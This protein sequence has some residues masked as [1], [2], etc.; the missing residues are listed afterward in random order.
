MKW[1]RKPADSLIDYTA[2]RF[3]ERLKSRVLKDI[4]PFIAELGIDDVVDAGHRTLAEVFKWL[5]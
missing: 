3:Y 4:E 1:L 5:P 2:D